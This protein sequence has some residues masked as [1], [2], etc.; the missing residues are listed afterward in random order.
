MMYSPLLLLLLLSL[1]SMTAGNITS[2]LMGCAK[3]RHYDQELCAVLAEAAEAQM[4]TATGPQVS[5]ITWAL[6]H[7][8]HDIPGVFAAAAQQVRCAGF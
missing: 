8:K 7:M 2:I 3:L 1:Q 4:S 6:A 5:Q